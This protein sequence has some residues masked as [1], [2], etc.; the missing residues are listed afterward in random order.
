MKKYCYSGN[1]HFCTTHYQSSQCL[2]YGDCD[3]NGSVTLDL[4]DFKTCTITNNDN[5]PMLTVIKLVINDDGG[6]MAIED[7]PL[8][9]DTAEVTSGVASAYSVGTY[10]VSEADTPGYTASFSG[11]CNDN[12]SVRTPTA[13]AGESSMRARTTPISPSSNCTPTV[14]NCGESRSRVENNDRNI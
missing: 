8:F 14:Y 6:T 13:A 2:Y 10:V 12:G 11:D 3:D 7:F 1:F 4:D 5:A 9:V